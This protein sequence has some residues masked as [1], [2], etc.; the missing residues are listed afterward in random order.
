[1][2]VAL[3]VTS[4]V[5]A[6]VAHAQPAEDAP[7]PRNYKPQPLN[8]RKQ[9]L[10]PAAYT[11]QARARVK[12]GDCAGALPAFDRAIDTSTEDP[13]LYRD[14]GLCHEQLGH[15][16]PAI[17]DF[18]AYL[19]AVPDAKDAP[20]IRDHLARLEDATSGRA[21]S[22]DNDDTNVPAVQADASAS[23]SVDGA[24][25][26]ADGKSRDK[27]DYYPDEDPLNTPLRRGKGFAVAPFFSE[28]KFFFSDSSFGDSNT[29]SETVGAQVRYSAGPVASLL[30]EVGYE[31]FN[32]STS[33]QP[34]IM[35]GLTSELG[36][37]LRF[38]LSP[39]YDNQWF[40]VPAIGYEHIAFTPTN[41]TFP[42]VSTNAIIPRVRVGYRHLFESAAG[43]DFSIDLGE[44]KWFVP[45]GDTGGA[46]FD[47]PAAPMVAANVML[48]WAL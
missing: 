20:T 36:V 28:H 7:S 15:P 8:L 45:S 14:R 32:A 31:H 2:P 38:P 10:G 9:E 42:S 18:R 17:D 29:W 24:S 44:S 22:A 13:T 43:L 39:D 26:S 12:A 37:E 21:P 19:T 4:V 47:I 33:D 34:F 25:A 5:V 40:L 11:T 1:M 46:S 30:V 41:P 23:V 35:A 16:Y 6:D 27:V 48:V 3:V